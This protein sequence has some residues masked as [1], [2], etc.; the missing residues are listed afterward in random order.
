M[1]RRRETGGGCRKRQN[2]EIASTGSDGAEGCDIVRKVSA[3]E[4]SRAEQSER[5]HISVAWH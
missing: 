1:H 4:F 3:P 2:R 5:E